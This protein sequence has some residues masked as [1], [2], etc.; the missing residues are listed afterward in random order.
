MSAEIVV[1]GSYNQDLIWTCE[2]FPNPGETI[3]GSFSSGFGGKG[4][5]QAVAAARTGISTT[6]VGSVGRD[7]FGRVIREFYDREG[8]N[9]HLEEQEDTPTGTA[10]IIVNKDGQNEII[11]APGANEKMSLAEIPGDLIRKAR[12]VICQLESNSDTTC[13]VLK[14]ARDAGVTTI[15]NPAPMRPDFQ[16][17]F[18]ENV[19]ILIPNEIEFVTLMRTL[20]PGKYETFS[21]TNIHQCSEEELHGLCR[22]LGVENIIITLGSKGC[23]VSIPGKYSLL[24]VSSAIKVID[25]TGAG[26]AF[27]GAFASG[28][29]QCDKDFFKAAANVNLVAGLSITKL[30]AAP[31]MPI[32]EEII[33]STPKKSFSITFIGDNH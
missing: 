15:L 28:F 9:Y 2:E 1:I 10:G 21:E 23:F 8:I 22:K 11:V 32:K 3:L 14:M 4:S 26:D 24:P 33:A 13:S 19:D 16:T 12:V 31:S 7:A 25:T 18:I 5:N 20:H 6:F 27:V 29:V 30:G 17:E